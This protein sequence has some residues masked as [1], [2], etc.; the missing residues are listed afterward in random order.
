MNRPTEMS[1][2]QLD[3]LTTAIVSAFPD[4]DEFSLLVES[5]L[6]ISLDRIT[7]HGIYDWM[8]MKAIKWADSRGPKL[9]DLIIGALNRNPENPQLLAVA[10]QY[11]LDEGAVGFEAMVLDTAPPQDVEEWRRQMMA[12]ERAVCRVEGPKFGTGFLV[13][14]GLVVT[15]YHVLDTIIEGPAKPD[16]VVLRFDYK[17]NANGKTVQQGKEYRL[18]GGRKWLA[19]SSPADKLDY[20]L[21]RVAGNP[22]KGTVAGQ[23]STPVRGTLQPKPYTFTKGDPLNIIQHP[24]AS[25]LKFAQ[26]YVEKPKAAKNRVGYKVNTAAGSSGSPCFNSNWEPVA[27]H[28]WGSATERI[29][30]GVLFSAIL[31]EW[32]KIAKLPEELGY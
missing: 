24:E 26:G 21:L 16:Q 15:N 4:P 6:G 20:A 2:E 23:R 10:A 28:H 29:N 22:E 7:R 3:N 17:M 13:G 12:C 32:Q 25:P 11:G 19:A 14:P 30:H 1:G 31:E 8:V 5:K 18:V 9:D 27:L